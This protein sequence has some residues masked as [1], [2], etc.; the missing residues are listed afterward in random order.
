MATANPASWL[1]NKM[2]LGVGVVLFALVA[3]V[4]NGYNDLVNSDENVKTALSQVEV[5][6]QRRFDLIPNFVASVEGSMTQ[7]KEVFGM[8]AEA[9]TRYSG[10]SQSTDPDAKI[11]SMDGL[12]SAFG[13]LLVVMENYPE[14]KSNERVAELMTQLEGT[15]N[16]IATE[17]RRYNDTVNDHNK[18]LRKF[19][20]NILAGF[21][22]FDEYARFASDEG[23]EKAPKVQFNNSK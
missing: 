13:R 3:W 19:P 12:N 20:R 22:N 1:A 17:R 16:R 11:A 9:R 5:V 14:L 6:Y 8:I 2:L 7:E 10:T 23:A 21:F 15:E 4:I 18:K